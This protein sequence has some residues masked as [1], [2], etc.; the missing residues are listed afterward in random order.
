MV[1]EASECQL[2]APAA[3][4]TQRG[5]HGD[6]AR[7]ILTPSRTESVADPAETSVGSVLPRSPRVRQLAASSPP[8]NGERADRQ[9]DEVG[10]ELSSDHLAQSLHRSADCPA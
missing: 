1:K 9:A 5:D 3:L 4:A 6:V 7:R 8:T 10:G 2:Y